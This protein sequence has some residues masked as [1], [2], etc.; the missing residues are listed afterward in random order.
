MEITGYALTI[1]FVSLLIG[2]LGVVVFRGGNNRSSRMFFV[3]VFLMTLWTATIG[4]F[5]VSQTAETATFL[6]KLCYFW[7]TAIG[8]FFL[9]FF[10][11][12][13][14][15]RR[16]P[17]P[18]FYGLIGS[19]A[20]YLFLYFFTDLII[21]KA[22]YIGGIVR[23]GWEFGS[24]WFLFYLIFYTCFL[25]GFVILFRRARH[26][27]SPEDRRNMRY[28]FWGILILISPPT[29]VNIIFPQFGYFRLIWLGPIMSIG[30]VSVFA[31]SIV[32]YQQMNIKAVTAEVLASVMTAVF[33]ANIFTEVS[34][35][36]AGRIVLFVLFLVFGYFLLRSVAAEVRQKELLAKLNDTLTHFNQQL[37][38]RVREQTQALKASYEVERTARVELEKLNDAKNQ[39][40]M[41]TQHH[42]RTPLTTIRWYLESITQGAFGAVAPELS[43]AVAS[44]K[45]AAERLTHLINNFLDITELK[46]GKDILAIAAVSIQPMMRAVLEELRDDMKRLDIMVQY[47]TDDARWPAVMVDPHKFKEVLFIVLDNAVRYNKKGGSIALTTDTA[48][49]RF[50]LKIEN[51]GLGITKAEQG[52]LFTD[53]FQRGEAA[54]RVHPVG[55]GIGLALARSIVSAHHGSIR[56]ESEGEEKTVTVVI[57]LPLAR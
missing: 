44:V 10:I 12:Y 27:A 50:I 43:Q 52:R 11:V 22:F 37:Q 56:I 41:I 13:P 4:L 28:V 35:G 2:S 15:N 49:D 53:L 48:H 32:R 34:W 6:V 3:T 54:K 25:S 51:T 30:W 16:V 47:P 57:D 33:F 23:Y 39:F 19:L 18:L 5:T 21:G 36:T 38:E 8:V 1:W 14:Y 24:L 45:S 20:A 55:R 9:F 29:L 7:G 17:R 40:I 31:Y 42:L 26:F 46:A